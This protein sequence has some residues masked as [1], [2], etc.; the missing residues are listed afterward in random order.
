M[1]VRI[2]KVEDVP[3]IL[4]IYAPYVEKTAYTFE[5]TVP[6]ME[7]FTER[8]QNITKQFPWLVWEEEG[9]VKGY[10]YASLPF[11]RPGYRWCCEVS[12]YLAPETQRKGVGKSLYAV[13][14]HILW[15]QGYRTIYSVVTGTNTGSVEFHKKVGY[16]IFA[17]FPKCGY[18]LGR[19]LD[20]I[21]LQK[22]SN[23]VEMPTEFPVPW[24]AIVENDEKLTDILAILSLS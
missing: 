20:V 6:M 12:I 10:A 19:N 17:T 24:T 9:C 4:E 8:F 7:E 22:Q 18:K 1:A 3:R 5:Y 16:E 2:A 23:A 15:Q 11:S 14:E 13:L 21:W